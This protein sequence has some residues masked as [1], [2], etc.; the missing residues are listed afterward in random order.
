MQQVS[1]E[2]FQTEVLDSKTPVV[3]KFFATWC[4]PCKLLGPV[5]EDVAKEH[6]DIKFVEV[7]IDQA[8]ALGSQY[9]INGVPTMLYVKDGKVVDRSVGYIAKDR[10]EQFL[11]RNK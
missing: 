11:E 1:P 4:G 2:Q 5:V 9:E 3:A 8:A 7:N 10:I 6:P